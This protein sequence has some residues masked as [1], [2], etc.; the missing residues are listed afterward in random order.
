MNAAGRI[1]TAV[2]IVVAMAAAGRLTVSLAYAWPI[3]TASGGLS[4]DDVA[5][6][7]SAFICSAVTWACAALAGIRA[8]RPPRGG[9]R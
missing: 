2:G 5:M 6:L 9:G 1:T 3:I 4:A 7:A 8:A